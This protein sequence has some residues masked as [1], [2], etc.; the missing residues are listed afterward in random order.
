MDIPSDAFFSYIAKPV[1]P[2][3]PFAAINVWARR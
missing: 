1:M 3:S 2:A